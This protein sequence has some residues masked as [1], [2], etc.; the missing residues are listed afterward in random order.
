MERETAELLKKV[1]IGAG[2]VIT[3]IGAVI[4]AEK[5]YKKVTTKREMQD[6]LAKAVKED[7]TE[8][9]IPEVS[10]LMLKAINPSVHTVIFEDVDTDKEITVPNVEVSGTEIHEGQ[11]YQIS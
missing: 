8:R 2:A 9:V 7:K 10:K 5:T 4:F 6:A 1:V 11:V 3:A